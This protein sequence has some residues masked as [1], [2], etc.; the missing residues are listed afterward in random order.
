[1]VEQNSDLV[2][3]MVD[4]QTLPFMADDVSHIILGMSGVKSGWYNPRRDL[5]H[6]E[7]NAQRVRSI[8]DEHVYRKIE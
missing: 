3:R 5:F 1:M 2:C 8:E 6:D 4:A 7:Y